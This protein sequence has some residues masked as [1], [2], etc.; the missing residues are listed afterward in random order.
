MSSPPHLDPEFEIAGRAVG[1]G[2]PCWVIAEVGSNHQLDLQVAKELIAAVAE[3]GADAVKF[4]SQK[5]DEQYLPEREDEQFLDFFRKTVLPE[6]WY[7]ELA[8]AAAEAGVVFFSSPTYQA[9]IPLLEEVGVPVYK[10]AS[11]QAATD[12]CLVTR[13]AETGKPMIVSTGMLEGS[14]VGALVERCLAAGNRK[15]AVLHCVSEY[16]VP[17]DRVNLRVMATY[18][19]R[20]GGPVGFSDHSLG[21]HVPLAAAALGAA[22]LEKHI[23]LDRSLPG[24]DHEFA[25]EPDEFTRMMRELR[26]VEATLGLPEKPALP[27]GLLKFVDLIQMRLVAARDIAAGE[28]LT[29]ELFLHR[30]AHVGLTNA[31]LGRLE[32]MVAASDIPAR[33]PL[34]ASHLRPVAEGDTE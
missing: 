10:I 2:H 33:S 24:P 27:E 15:V 5:L 9:A 22:V 17:P 20:F 18:R 25:L 19:Q 13:V 4:Q 16:P 11:P 32:G 26:D 12:P 6:E 14:G 23:T 31:E 8:A 34:E 30:R 29:P 1:P 28:P 21:T 3:A 7:P